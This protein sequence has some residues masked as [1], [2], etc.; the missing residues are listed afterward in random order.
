MHAKIDWQL[1]MKGRW[2]SESWQLMM[3]ATLGWVFVRWREKKNTERKPFLLTRYPHHKHATV[4]YRVCVLFCPCKIRVDLSHAMEYLH[5]WVHQQRE[6][7]KTRQ[8]DTHTTHTTQNGIVLLCFA[9]S[10]TQIVAIISLALQAF[11]FILKAVFGIV[12]HLT[13]FNK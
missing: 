9:F 12:L 3:T 6:Q 11:S 13:Q 10:V 4:H 1:Q 8:N 7:K 5:V 2:V